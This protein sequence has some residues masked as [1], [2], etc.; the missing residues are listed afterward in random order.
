MPRQR[1]PNDLSRS[2]I[3]LDLDTTL[4]AVVE[5]SLSSWLVAG[6]VPGVERQPLKK[7]KTDENALLTLL[8]RWRDEAVRSGHKISRIAVAFEAGRDGFW[9]ARWLKARGIEAHVTYVV[10]DNPAFRIQREPGRTQEGT[11]Y[12]S[13]LAFIGTGLWL[14]VSCSA[15]AAEGVSSI[16][17]TW[18]ITSASM[19][20][21]DTNETS[22][23]FGD[24]PTGYLQYSPGGHM[25]V[26]L[27]SDNI[28]QPADALYTDSERVE[29]HKAILAAYSGTY[30]VEGN[31]VIHHVLASWWPHFNGMDQ[32]R[33]IER[34]GVT[35]QI[36]AFD[37]VLTPDSGHESSFPCPRRRKLI[38]AAKRARVGAIGRR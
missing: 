36:A 28:R 20:A 31:M 7:L 27:A 4:I 24:H 33:Y 38:R 10:Q 32:I 37:G 3:L 21:L 30:R 8:N 2:L 12:R 9:L 23:P 19:L 5:L 26:F 34:N 11:M 6:I 35:A 22:H 18:E 1:K 29:I 25:V 13:G 17:G 16:V 15:M 14:L